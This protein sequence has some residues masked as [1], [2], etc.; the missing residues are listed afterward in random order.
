MSDVSVIL[1]VGDI[2]KISHM[3][4]HSWNNAHVF[5]NCHHIVYCVIYTIADQYQSR[6]K[7]SLHRDHLSPSSNNNLKPILSYEP[8]VMYYCLIII[9]LI[10]IICLTATSKRAD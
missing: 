9:S 8:V 5:W 4:C 3:F 1:G 7:F 2:A 10:C 6:F